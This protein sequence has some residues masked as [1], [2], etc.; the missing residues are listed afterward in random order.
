MKTRKISPWMFFI[1]VLAIFW[2][3]ESSIPTIGLE[4][5]LLN[6]QTNYIM[7]YYNFR[8]FQTASYFQIDFSQSDITVT[9]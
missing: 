6:A 5:N 3:T 1:L 9:D 8:Q 7:S 4:N 2:P